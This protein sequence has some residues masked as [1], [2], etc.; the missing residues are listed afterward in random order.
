MAGSNLSSLCGEVRVCCAFQRRLEVSRRHVHVA[1]AAFIKSVT[2]RL[3]V[4]RNVD[5]YA[6]SGPSLSTGNCGNGKSVAHDKL[7]SDTN[8]QVVVAM[9]ID[10]DCEVF[11]LFADLFCASD[12]AMIDGWI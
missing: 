11:N 9:G 2:N 6:L 5:G 3:I 10:V 8:M 12:K 4:C 1:V 7:H